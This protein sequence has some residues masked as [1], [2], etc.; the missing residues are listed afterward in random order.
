MS[1][2]AKSSVRSL[3]TME[4]QF[5]SGSFFAARILKKVA[6]LAPCSSCFAELRLSSELRAP[7]ASGVGGRRG[8]VGWP[9]G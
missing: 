7:A 9:D 1:G 2:Q 4:K 6:D 5:Q 3:L 8:G